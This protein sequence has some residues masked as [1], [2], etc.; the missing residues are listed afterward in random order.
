ML[1]RRIL[2]LLCLL[3]CFGF[4]IAYGEWLSWLLLKAM[5]LLPWLS[6]LLSLPAMLT[7]K[8][9]F[10]CPLQVTKGEKIPLRMQIR[11]PLP[12][13]PVQWCFH[14][15]E[16]YSGDAWKYRAGESVTADHCGC[17]TVKVKKA[18]RYDYL[19]LFRLPLGRRVEQTVLIYPQAVP[20][21]DLPSLKRYLAGSWK[22]KRGGG[23]AENY[24]LREYHEGDD[25]RQMHW[26]LTAKTGKPVLREPIVPVRG[27]LC[28]T[29]ILGGSPEVIDEKLG[30]L[31]HVSQRLLGKELPHEIVC[32]TGEGQKVLGVANKDELHAAITA[33]LLC[34][35]TAQQRMPTLQAS[36]LYRI[37]GNYD[38][39]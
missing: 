24:D 28:L 30:K 18:W 36:W 21:D 10:L 15:F 4:Y 32:L 33:L 7:L 6:L 34:T 37:G 39:A 5:L 27:K 38:E 13:P 22:P 31:L 16:S 20:V 11:C 25:L 9:R 26:K 14:V 1:R 19:G 8:A 35:P 23:F 2:Y 12:V 29:M 17:L 3:G